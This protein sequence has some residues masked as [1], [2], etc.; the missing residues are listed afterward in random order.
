MV[1]ERRPGTCFVHFRRRICDGQEGQK[2]EEVENGI[3]EKAILSASEGQGEAQAQGQG[4]TQ[5]EASK[6]RLHARGWS[7]EGRKESQ[8][9]GSGEEENTACLEAGYRSEARRGFHIAF[10]KRG[11][12]DP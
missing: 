5:A 2:G 4:S 8:T 9:Q 7:Q 12:C 11:G 10:G 6:A 3:E 1:A